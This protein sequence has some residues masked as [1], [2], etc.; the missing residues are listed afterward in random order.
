MTDNLEATKEIPDQ[1]SQKLLGK[2]D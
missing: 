2:L 1:E